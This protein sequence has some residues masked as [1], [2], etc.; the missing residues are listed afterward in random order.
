MC[1]Q[2]VQSENHQRSLRKTPLRS[3]LLDLLACVESEVF[4]GSRYSS[5]SDVIM[6]L[7][8]CQGRSNPNDE[9]VFVDPEPDFELRRQRRGA[10]AFRR[11]GGLKLIGRGK[12][13]EF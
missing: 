11:Q 5:F 6:H 7:R 4:K 9:H 13:E 12:T 2:M 10:G 8:I 1:S 3:A